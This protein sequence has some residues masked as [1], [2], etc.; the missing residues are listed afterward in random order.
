LGLDVTDGVGHRMT[1]SVE[2]DF[3]FLSADANHDRHVDLTDFTF[4]AANFNEVGRT[5]GQG[6]FDDD[7]GGRVDLTDFTILAA[8]FN[9]A[10]PGAATTTPG[11]ASRP[12]A[13]PVDQAVATVA[14]PTRGLSV[15]SGRDRIADAVL[16][17]SGP[18]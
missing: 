16:A 5:F 17:A 11:A 13:R 14:G 8:N 2:Q 12:A 4:L 9:K 1:G 10:L 6:N 15:F 3:F 18:I 7:P